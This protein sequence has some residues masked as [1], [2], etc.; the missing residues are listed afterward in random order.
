MKVGK[1][2]SLCFDFEKYFLEGKMMS[3]HIQDYF[4]DVVKKKK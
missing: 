3:P 2:P 4:L 1:I